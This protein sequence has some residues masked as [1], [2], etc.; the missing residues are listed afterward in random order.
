MLQ[1]PYLEEP[2]RGQV[3]PTLPTE[4]GENP[5]VKFLESH[6]PACLHGD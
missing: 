1:F 5:G 2:L 4:L 6:N 3:P